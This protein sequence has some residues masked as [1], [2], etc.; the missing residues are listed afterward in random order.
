MSGAAAISLNTDVNGTI[1]PKNDIDHFKFTINS[2]GT[3]TVWLTNLPANYNLVVLN[4]SGTQIGISQNNGNQNE[5]ISLSVAAGV[6]YAK[7]FPKGN[8]N[9]AT[10]CYTLRVQTITAT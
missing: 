7:V 8:A 3:I 6:Y 10:S 1:S 4:S 5:S 2:Y 9:S